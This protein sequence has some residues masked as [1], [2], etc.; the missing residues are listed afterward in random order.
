M[1]DKEIKKNS[2]LK[3]ISLIFATLAVVYTL[4]LAFN[5]NYTLLG[6]VLSLIV[7]VTYVI[8]LYFIHIR[9]KAQT[10][11]GIFL[12]FVGFLLFIFLNLVVCTNNINTGIH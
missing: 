3:A 6:R 9:F 12:A 2:T 5:F 8:N 10:V 1:E 11:L 7:W 4:L